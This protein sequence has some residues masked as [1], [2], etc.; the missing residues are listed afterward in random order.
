MT[1]RSSADP[2]TVCL[3]CGEEL[4]LG[5]LE[6]Y[7]RGF[8]LDSCCEETQEE[9]LHAL[10]LASRQD[11]R[12]WLRLE[13]GLDCRD[14][15]DGTTM[16]F[17]L[18]LGAVPQK[19]AKEFV[20]DHHS[21]CPPPAGWRWGHAVFNG[22]ELIGVAM[23]GRPVARML[24]ATKVVE[25]NRVCV[26]AWPHELVWNACSM[27]YGAAAREA[28]ARGFERIITYTLEEEEAT[29]LRA[30]GWDREATTAGGSWN[31]RGRSREDRSPTCRKVR[32]GRVLESCGRPCP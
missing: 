15:L 2:P 30:V 10:E 11:R 6:I 20:R 7:E 18:R 5:L 22:E 9:Q 21:H 32:W 19:V 26:E 12:E 8:L 13:A 14:L 31:R 17:G 3:Y 4:R 23:V 24:D 27:L 29:A 1:L 16:D 25:V 28:K